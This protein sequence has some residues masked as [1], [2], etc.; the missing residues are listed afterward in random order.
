M[1]AALC[2]LLACQ[3]AGEALRDALH[4][5]APGPV[6]GM[7]LLAA[8]LATADRLPKAGRLPSL[9]RQVNKASDTL[10][11]HMGLL[12][13]PAGVGIIVEAPRMQAEWLPLVAGVV[14]STVIGLMVTAGVMH[15]TLARSHVH[16]AAKDLGETDHDA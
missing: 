2:I 5:P 8:G 16:A 14:G 13:V 9:A 12:F 4:L 3:L 1:I 11:R 15:L 10:V 7:L 6:I